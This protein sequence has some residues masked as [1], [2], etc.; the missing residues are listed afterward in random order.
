MGDGSAARLRVVDALGIVPTKGYAHDAIISRLSR[1]IAGVVQDVC[2][3]RR[4]RGAHLKFTA[5]LWRR[6]MGAL[7]ATPGKVFAGPRA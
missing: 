4:V 2:A 5:L 7:A 1:K 6:D 3:P